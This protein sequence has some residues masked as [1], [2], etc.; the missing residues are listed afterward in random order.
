M[1][2]NDEKLGHVPIYRAARVRSVVEE[3]KAHQTPI[4]AE[5]QRNM[6]RLT[7]VN[8]QRIVG[9][10][11]HLVQFAFRSSRPVLREVVDVELHQILQCSPL[12][13][14]SCRYIDFGA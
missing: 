12:L 5:K 7:P 9:K 2:P 4:E 14:A 3:R 13:R 10:T 8:V 6:S 11:P 1:F